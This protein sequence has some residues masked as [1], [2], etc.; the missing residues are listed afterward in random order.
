[1]T[2]GRHIALWKEE[3]KTEKD[4]AVIVYGTSNLFFW[5]EKHTGFR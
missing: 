5:F 4:G 1:M 2:M 3:L